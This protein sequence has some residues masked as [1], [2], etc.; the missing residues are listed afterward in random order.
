MW[1]TII[2]G[3][4]IGIVVL[5]KVPE[6]LV[7]VLMLGGAYIQYVFVLFG[8][9]I[10]RRQFATA[11]AIIFIP[12]VLLF[13][14][15]R[16]LHT[17]E[18]EA[19]IGR[20][21]WAFIVTS[22]AM[23][24]VFLIGLS[25]TLAPVYGTQKTGEYFI[26]GM[27][28][29]LLAFVFLRDLASARRFLV[30]VVVIPAL[31]ICI[32]SVYTIATRGTLFVWMG[33]ERAATSSG[34]FTIAGHGGISGA[35]L[36]ILAAFLALAAGRQ[37]T[38]WKALPILALPI[39]TFY[40]FFAG[41]R[42]NFV[43]FFFLVVVGFFFA[44]K[45]SRKALLATFGV[46]V[47]SGAILVALAPEELRERM[48]S[49]WLSGETA[50]GA[51][52]RGRLGWAIDCVGF[53]S[54]SPVIGWG[55]GDYTILED[56]M[57]VYDYPHNMYAEVL[58]ENGIVGFTVFVALWY[59][60]LRRLWRCLRDEEPGTELY[61]FA[62][63]GM[64]LMAMEFFTGAAH[65]GLAHHSCTLLISSAVILR[66]TFLAEEARL[67]EEHPEAEEAEAGVMAHPVLKA[68]P[69]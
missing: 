22:V 9:Q 69:L 67:S 29:M 61:G 18:R 21:N 15:M 43:S 3:G 57:D 8:Y 38:K 7:V 14:M 12:L 65:F 62:V 42:S 48:L 10:T 54:Q 32:T 37:G 11:G 64:C 27:A 60:V 5:T 25:Y 52:A 45:G 63:F 53:W 34:E 24:A 28:P 17:R 30:W 1:V 31:T 13:L 6:M 44:Y 39:L 46:L 19:I 56:G 41:T 51:A 36:M 20:P 66:T 59:L 16:M 23:G 47:L 49:S 26:F 55:T 68:G 40:I 50:P 58:A 33:G 4:V 35:A 2:V